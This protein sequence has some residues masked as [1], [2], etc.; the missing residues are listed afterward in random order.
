MKL[1]A[2]VALFLSLI[3]VLS[4]SDYGTKL[5]EFEKMEYFIAKARPPPPPKKVSKKN[6][7]GKA[8][9][10]KKNKTV[11]TDK[12]KP[13]ATK[14]NTTKKST[15]KKNTTTAIKDK[16]A[17]TKKN[18]TK[19]NTTTPI[20]DKLATTKKNKTA[21]N[22]KDKPVATKKGKAAV[23]KKESVSITEDNASQDIAAVTID[24][25][26]SYAGPTET[27]RT[28]DDLVSMDDDTFGS[29]EK[30]PSDSKNPDQLSEDPFYNDTYEIVLREMKEMVQELKHRVDEYKDLPIPVT[31]ETHHSDSDSDLDF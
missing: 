14:K 26:F 2:W 19:K 27:E 23:A 13:A 22:K 5:A 24:G 12:D 8:V 30:N 31:D 20:K 10:I 15:T 18:T 9:S 6:T 25:T 7:T 28:L 11:T 16:P 1:I 3:E 17:T 21:T 4:D 29:E